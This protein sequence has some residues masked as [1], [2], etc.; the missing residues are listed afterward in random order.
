MHV[1]AE[2]CPYNL[3]LALDFWTPLGDFL[4]LTIPLNP[5]YAAAGT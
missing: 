1:S 4:V 3:A 5:G 2:D